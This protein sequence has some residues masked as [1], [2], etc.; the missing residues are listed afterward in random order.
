[1]DDD[2]HMRLAI[3]EAWRYQCVTYPN[4]AVGALVARRGEILSIEAHHKAGHSHAEVLAF[5]SAYEKMSG[6]RLPVD[7]EESVKVHDFLL[8]LPD[9]FFS[10]CELFVTL[11]PCAH[12]GR[13][14]S[15]AGLIERLFPKRVVVAME[16]PVPEHAGG[17]KRLA[18][19]GIE[20]T[21]WVSA[22]LARDLIEPFMIWRERAFVLF[23]L[24]QTSNGRIG[25]GYLSC[26]DSL[27]HTH[28]LRS[29]V[30]RMVIGGNTVRID[31]PRLD[32]RHCGGEAPDL[33][34]F[35]SRND[36]DG[37]IPL[38]DIADREVD[39]VDDLSP[40]LNIPG[41]LLVEGGEGM[42]RALSDDI[43]WFL[44]YQTPKLS[45]NRLSYNIDKKIEFL[46]TE[47]SGADLMIWSRF[48]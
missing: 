24:A 4:P 14:P 42:L 8:S 33:T 11:E 9:G 17:L 37:D 28:M 18:E 46:H 13:T 23:K 40:L 32:A 22:D 29:V 35:S 30:D 34:I 43:D 39:I 45:T 26:A 36:F 31:R 2:F 19:A 38:F 10:D 44:I 41:F 15:C 20:I 25:G 47:R 48:G 6:R 7:R 12:D 27:R 21:P 1:M 5:A 16:D 3:D